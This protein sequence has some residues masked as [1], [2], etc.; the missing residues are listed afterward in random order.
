MRPAT[1][2]RFIAVV[3]ATCFAAGL[4]SVP[5]AGQQ[6]VRQQDSGTDRVPLHTIVPD[7]P[8]VAR[9]DRI[10][11]E[12]K[13][14]FE[15]TR[16]G[17][18]RRIAV[19]RSTNRLF[20]RPAIRAVRASTFHPL[21]KDAELPG[22]KACRTFRFYLEPVDAGGV[23][24]ASQSRSMRVAASSRVVPKPIRPSSWPAM[25]ATPDAGKSVSA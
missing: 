5:A 6:G 3:I 8:K 23:E 21:P 22:I 25:T 1:T 24:Q 12:V 10:E 19:R 18:T 4:W 7:Y 20:E 11:G 13:V 9:R 16:E 15:I 17:R 2:N 14:C